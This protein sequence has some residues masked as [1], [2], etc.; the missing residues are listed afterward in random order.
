MRPDIIRQPSSYDT[1][2]EHDHSLVSCGKRRSL[3]TLTP[4]PFASWGFWASPL[5]P[6]ETQ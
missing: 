2:Q 6:R 4:M 1:L 5:R 3:L